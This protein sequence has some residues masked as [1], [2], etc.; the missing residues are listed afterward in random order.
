M[1]SFRVEMPDRPLWSIRGR[2]G[3]TVPFED[4]ESVKYWFVLGGQ[5]EDSEAQIRLQ[6]RHMTIW[7]I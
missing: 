3:T 2:V 5:E 1:I 6:R 4:L 7:T